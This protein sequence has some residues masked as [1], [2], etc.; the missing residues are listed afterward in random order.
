MAVNLPRTVLESGYVY[1]FVFLEISM[2]A[3]FAIQQ[4]W[5]RG[6]DLSW[7]ATYLL[8]D[9]HGMAAMFQN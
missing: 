5:K 1:I 3:F 9:K 8:Q 2:F 7:T 4:N 6:W